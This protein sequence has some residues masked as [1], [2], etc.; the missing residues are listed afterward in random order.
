VERLGGR[1]RGEDKISL[2]GHG[3]RGRRAPSA[4][5]LQLGHVALM[6]VDADDI[7]ARLGQANGDRRPHGAEADHPNGYT[8]IELPW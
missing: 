4:M 5:V 6:Q 2:L 1:Q 7:E 3:A 8:H